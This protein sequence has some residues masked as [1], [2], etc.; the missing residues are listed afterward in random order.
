MAPSSAPKP[1]SRYHHFVPQFILRNFSHPYQPASTGKKCR[2]S[3][4][5]LYPGDEAVN[6]IDLSSPNVKIVE[7]KV[8]RTF[9]IQDMYI[10]AGHATNKQHIEEM[11]SKL[12]NDA[13]V[14]IS[15]IRKTFEGGE[16][17]VALTRGERNVVRKFLFVMKYRK[18]STHDRFF[19]E[20]PEEYI[21]DD[22][23]IFL[24]YMRRKGFKKPIEVWLDNIKA[25]LEI[26]MDVGTAW[27]KELGEKAYPLDAVW[28]VMQTSMFYMSFCTPSDL[29]NEFIM[30]E[31]GYGIHEGPVSIST[32]RETAEV[33]VECHIEYHTF[34]HI[35]PKL[36]IILRAFMLP[37]AVEDGDPEVREMREKYME[38]NLS[39]HNDQVSAR[40]FLQDLPITKPMNSYSTIVHGRAVSLTGK[41]HVH[42]QKDVFY[43][44]FF[45]LSVEHVAKIN[46]IFLEEA[47]PT[48]I[49]AFNNKSSVRRAVEYYLG[50]DDE[51]GGKDNGFK[52]TSGR[53]DDPRLLY[54]KKLEQAVKLLGGDAKAIYKTKDLNGEPKKR[55]KVVVRDKV[56]DMIKASPK[57]TGIYTI[58]CELVSSK[59]H[60]FVAADV[61]RREERA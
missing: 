24:E 28:F 47:Y 3:K 49:I 21:G 56:F 7:T 59:L 52:L 53:D 54:L 14:V 25:F 9:G 26:K 40:S 2:K 51:D 57:A 18:P 29:D 61:S 60:L 50:F 4:S 8:S 31:N 34:A 27:E 43:F 55:K 41:E 44:R 38:L 48:G 46:T 13:A 20:T 32:D 39:L 11:F 30:T 45:P 12:E 36:T 33:E 17:I 22:K 6:G 19:F 23:E 1:D 35:S 58:L 5:G 37:L 42:S 15:K 10:D 16:K